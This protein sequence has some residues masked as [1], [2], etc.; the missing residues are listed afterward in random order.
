MGSADRRLE[1][2]R[3]LAVVVA[4]AALVWLG[5]GLVPWWPPMWLAP[6]PALVYSAHTSSRLATGAAFL[7]WLLGSLALLPV[8]AAVGSPVLAWLVS[9]APLAAIFAGGVLLYRYLLVR[10]APFSATLALPALWVC[11]EWARHE[12]SAH[13]TAVDLAYTQL[14]LLPFLQLASLTG[15]WGMS[16]LLLW[17]PACAAACLHLRRREPRLARALL[18][19]PGAVL[20][21]VLGFGAWRLQAP[22]SGPVMTVGLIASD[23]ERD[24]IA[25]PGAPATQ[26][27]SAYG[28]QARSLAA[29]GAALIV[30][31][32]K[33]AV[34]RDEDEPGYDDL[35]QHLADE[36]RV[37]VVVGV[38][39]VVGGG[40]GKYNRAYVYAPA[41]AVRSYDKRHML[42]PIESS[43]IPGTQPLLIQQGPATVGVAIC[44]DMDFTSMSL[45]YGQQLAG[46]MLVPAW[47][48]DADRVFHGHMAIMRGVEGGFSVARAGRNGLLT[49]SD[50]RGR[51][52]GEVR[53][54]SAPFATLLVRVPVGHSPTLFLAWGN[55]FA[56]V[57]VALLGLVV[58]RCL[59]GRV[60]RDTTQ[61]QPGLVD[62]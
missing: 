11:Q 15:P 37:T 48:F 45:T 3:F 4:T 34:V 47:D 58:A 25:G 56:W 52:L 51:V 50:S 23:T 17:I 44:K 16:F 35:F 29:A 27:L 54:D 24:G 31:P 8:L 2:V 10:G 20:L 32:E 6:L 13:G 30:L 33:L 57:N 21:C 41:L 40:S 7:G 55:W 53:S 19:L 22:A 49:V 26:L 36:A 1:W 28:G 62:S 60:R 42:P 12:L 61:A 43:L 39:R 46:L 38:G 14:D 18:I 9:F 5:N 59:A